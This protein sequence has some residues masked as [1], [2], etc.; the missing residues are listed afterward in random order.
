MADSVKP[1]F[2][3]GICFLSW[4][5]PA[6][7]LLATVA[8]RPESE[9]FGRVDPPAT[10]EFRYNNGA[11]P[12]FLDPGLMVADTDWRIAGMLFEGL[13]VK[14]PKTLQPRPGV[15]ERWEISPDGLAY[16]FH[17]RKNARWSDGAPVTAQDFVYSWTR[18]LDPATA[19]RYANQLYLIVNAEPFNQGKI[20]EATEL[21]LRAIDDFTLQVRLREPVPYFLFL[22]ANAPLYPVPRTVMEQFGDQ[23]TDPDKIVGNGPFR[24]VEHRTHDRIVLERNP[25]YW[26]AK[27][28]HLDR[29]VAYSIDDNYTSAN[30][31]ESGRLDYLPGYFPAEYVPSM[32]GRFRDF[33]SNPQLAIYYYSLNVT[34]PPL[35]NVLVRRA[36][37]MAVDR[38]AI[39][40][41]LLRGGQIPGAHFVPVGLPDYQSPPGPE[42]DPQKAARLL[43]EAGYPNGQGFPEMELRFNTLDT[44]R[45]IAEAIQQMWAKHLNIHVTLHN[46][47]W[48]AFLKTRQNLEHDIARDGWI[49]DYPDPSAFIDLLESTNGNNDTGWKNAE[50]D[51][52]LVLSR[53]E[54]DPQKRMR[55]LQQCE[56]ILLREL[57]VL[58]IY[59]YA[60]NA[61]TKPYVRGIYPTS[62]D[63]HPLNEVCIDRHWRDRAESEDGVC[64]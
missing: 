40:D 51:R 20:K 53:R 49:G 21:G 29:V 33:N 43:A 25:R 39:T 2:G 18:L 37:S 32:R 6:L 30:L 7:L 1:I 59:T 3:Q 41:D 10:S 19:A 38:S 50:Y 63:V 56:E 24:L 47:E 16:T 5:L 52:L 64:E 35:D 60:S 9:Y 62:Q 12:E 42:F 26:N 14:D 13:T 11:E 46:E 57:P 36:L 61:L 44:H 27:S 48:A 31:Y 8:C 28:V 4:A 15:A 17:L 58:P 34:H 22:T 23:W 55:L 54:T 45:K